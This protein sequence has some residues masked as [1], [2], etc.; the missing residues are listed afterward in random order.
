MKRFFAFLVAAALSA[1]GG[2]TAELRLMDAPPEGVTAVKIHVASMQ[3]HVDDKDKAKDADPADTSIDADGKWQTL[4]VDKQIDLVAHQGEDA[5]AVLGQLDLPEGK[6]TQIRLVLDTSKPNVA[7]YDGA[8]CSLDLSKIAPS[9][10][11][12]SHVFKALD[13]AGGEAQIWVDLELDKALTKKGDCFQLESKLKLHKV[14]VD[15]S[16]V[17]F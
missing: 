1:C 3:V 16:D 15:G 10:I 4:A 5:A 13:P 2:A 11:K 12:I 14:K 17:Q 8:D 7:T 6:I 9:G